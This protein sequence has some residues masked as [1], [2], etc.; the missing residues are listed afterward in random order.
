MMKKCITLFFCICCLFC[1][2]Q[3]KS[4]PHHFKLEG[5]IKG[6]ETGSVYFAYVDAGDKFKVDSAHVEKGQFQFK[7]SINGPTITFISTVK[8]AIPEEDDDIMKTDGKNSTLFFLEPKPMTAELEA[9]D[10]KNGKFTASFSE[11]E[12]SVYIHQLNHV[13]DHFQA[14]NDSLQA[15]TSLNKT[16]KET[17]RAHLASLHEAENNRILQGFFTSHPR[18]YVTAY[19]VSIAHFKL[20]SLTLFY[21]RLPL[22]VKLSAY[23]KDIKEKIEKKEK[24][25][26]GKTAPAF[27][28]AASTG[29]SVALKDFKGK[30]VLLQYWSSSNNA[31]RA[32]NREL[33]PVYNR[34]KDKNFAILGISL[35]G[36][37][38]KGVWEKTIEKDQLPWTQ[39]AALKSNHNQ[40]VLQYDV[41]SLPANFLIG[42]TG[43]IVATDLKPEQLDQTLSRICNK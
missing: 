15:L 17:A 43:K 10:F 23:G 3:K 20:D 4:I 11:A 9:G 37:K 21:H 32:N 12:Y 33:I 2:A 18:S 29:D 24:V 35:D 6:I 1:F 14:Q 26:V 13:M 40:A 27:K 19:L 34:F 30:Y 31:S 22:P 8:R 38:T 39:L 42:P 28:Q 5:T 41:Q 7:G 25:M 36:Q 16:Q